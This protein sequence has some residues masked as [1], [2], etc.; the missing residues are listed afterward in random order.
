MEIVTCEECEN[1]D[2]KSTVELKTVHTKP[3]PQR[4]FYDEDG[5]KHI[6]NPDMVVGVY[7]CSN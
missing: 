3:F 4:V 7:M 2:T 6:H 5:V 1:K